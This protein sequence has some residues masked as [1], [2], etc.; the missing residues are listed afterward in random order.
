MDGQIFEIQLV[1]Q[2]FP[3]AF[4]KHA[5]ELRIVIKMIFNGRLVPSSDEQ[6]LP[7]SV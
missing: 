1:Q 2:F 5:E 6:N 7:D 3:I 4:A